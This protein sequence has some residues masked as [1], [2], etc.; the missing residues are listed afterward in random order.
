MRTL[1]LLVV[2][3]LAASSAAQSTGPTLYVSQA[4]YFL[5]V[6]DANKV[7]SFVKI[8][9]V[10]TGAGSPP[11]ISPPTIPPPGGDVPPPPVVPPTIDVTSQVKTWTASVNH[12]LGRQAMALIW[13]TVGDKVLQGQIPPDQGSAAITATVDAAFNAIGGKQNWTTWRAN[14]AGL[15]Q[16]LQSQGK[17]STKEQVG[18]FM[19]QVR[20]GLNASPAMEALSEKQELVLGKVEELLEAEL[21][22]TEAG[23]SF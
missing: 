15:A 18:N 11:V 13:G 19:L 9:N 4:G 7:P 10:I 1:T 21:E 6:E 3:T 23:P 22:K 8:T 20:D 5:V 12:P 2:S 14:V 16:Q 17:Y